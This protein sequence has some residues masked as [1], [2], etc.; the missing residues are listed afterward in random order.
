MIKETGMDGKKD[1]KYHEQY[2]VCYL[3]ILGYKELVAK[4]EAESTETAI[5]AS[6]ADVENLMSRLTENEQYKTLVEEIKIDIMSDSII[7]RRPLCEFKE[8]KDHNLNE[9]KT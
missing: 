1:N 3:D 4:M 5:K 2:I 6:F 9:S 8:I 7:I